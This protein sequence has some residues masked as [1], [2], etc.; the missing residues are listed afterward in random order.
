VC[1]CA[2]HCWQKAYMDTKRDQFIILT[3]CRVPPSI[4]KRKMQNMDQNDTVEKIKSVAHK[5]IETVRFYL[6]LSHTHTLSLSRSLFLSLFLCR[7]HSLSLFLSLSLCLS[8]SFSFSRARSPSISL[9]LS[10][11][12]SLPPP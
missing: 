3:Y 11:A 6:S 9:S 2:R 10:P 7:N 1:L 4:T 5:H 8:L 12:L